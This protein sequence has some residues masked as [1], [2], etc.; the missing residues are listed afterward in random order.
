MMRALKEWHRC[1]WGESTPWRVVGAL[2]MCDVL[3]SQ[4]YGEEVRK[5]GTA[6]AIGRNREAL[7]SQR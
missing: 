1:P 6:M 4:Y 2:E 3:A 5:T 7:L